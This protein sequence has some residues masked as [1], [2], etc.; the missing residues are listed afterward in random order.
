MI[1]KSALE[2]LLA[3]TLAAVSGIVGKL[4]YLSSLRAH[5]GG[6][7]SHWGLARVHGDRTAQQALA[8]AHSLLFLRV[9]RTSLRT[10]RGDVA[11]SSEALQIPPTEYVDNLRNHLPTLLPQDLSGGSARH[12]SSVLHALSS[13]AKTRRDATPP[14]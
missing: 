13:L 11:V 14:A 2:D 10:L 12:F 7:Y 8:E 5:G 1:L 3:T 4:E 9:L 6:A